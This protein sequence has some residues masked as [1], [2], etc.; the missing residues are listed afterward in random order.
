LTSVVNFINI[1]QEAFS[2]EEPKFATKDSQYIS[3]FF[4]LL[5]PMGVKAAR[6]MLMKLTPEDL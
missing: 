2:H 4:A 3:G 1:L 5:G 6:K